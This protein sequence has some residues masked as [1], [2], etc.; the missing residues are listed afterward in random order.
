MT[1]QVEFHARVQDMYDHFWNRQQE[2]CEEALKVAQDDHHQV[3][4]AAALLEGNIKRLAHSVSMDSP[5]ASINWAVADIHVIED[6]QVAT[7]GAC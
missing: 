4:A 7:E 1:V 5:T 6:A 2:S 3:L